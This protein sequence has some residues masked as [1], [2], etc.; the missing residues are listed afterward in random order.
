MSNQAS[1]ILPVEFVQQQRTGECL[2]ACTAM[3]LNYIGK[4]VAYRRLV[5]VLE[6][7]PMVGTPSSKITNLVRIGVTVQYQ[8]GTIASLLNHIRSDQPCIVFVKTAEL[9]YRNDITDH[10]LV[11]IGFDQQHIYLHD[12]EFRGSPLR[13]AYGDFDLAWRE[14][15][16]MYAVL[17]A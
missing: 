17:T 10:A 11:V 16:E 3:V 4:P 14:R 1:L 7:I 5:S 13:V 9:P 2:V 8:R 15:D 6:V 12:P